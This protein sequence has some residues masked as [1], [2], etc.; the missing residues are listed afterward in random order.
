ML[1]NAVGTS[2]GVD[3][4]EDFYQTNHRTIFGVMESLSRRN[5]PFDF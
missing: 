5:Q 1:D 3:K 4:E 2:C